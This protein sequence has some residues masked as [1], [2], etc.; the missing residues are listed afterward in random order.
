VHA[1]PVTVVEAIPYS[2]R[3]QEGAQAERGFPA[4]AVR[5]QAVGTTAADLR[6]CEK[7]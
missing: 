5:R 7:I 1:T 6:R 2:T 4:C 3:G